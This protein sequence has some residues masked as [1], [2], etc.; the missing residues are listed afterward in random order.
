METDRNSQLHLWLEMDEVQLKGQNEDGNFESCTEQTFN[1][2]FLLM[3][4][5]LNKQK[6][7]YGI[8]RCRRSLPLHYHCSYQLERDFT[9]AQILFSDIIILTVRHRTCLQKNI[10]SHICSHRDSTSFPPLNA[11]DQNKNS[12]R[13]PQSSVSWFKNQTDSS[14]H[15]SC[16]PMTLL[17]FRTTAI[18][19]KICSKRQRR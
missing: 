1:T 8:L 10:H 3:E 17:L 2:S 16:T 4:Q 15:V 19:S 5:S 11:P 18:S 12:H 9:N 7:P 6:P 14:L 13:N